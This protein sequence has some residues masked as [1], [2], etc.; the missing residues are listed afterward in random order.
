MTITPTVVGI[1]CAL[2]AVHFV[3]REAIFERARIRKGQICFPPVFGLRAT[4]W[5]GTPMFLFA[6]YKVSNEA[7]SSFDWV[8]PL[9]FVGLALLAFFSNPGTIT[10]NAEEISIKRFLGLRVKRLDWQS[11]SSAVHSTA[12]KE[13]VLYA[14]DGTSIT[15]TR[16]HVDPSRFEAELQKR[17]GPQFIQQ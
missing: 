9:I 6:A 12:Q 11:V 2:I 17:L 4:F 13:I 14:K 1:V 15:H 10:L 16:F 3:M 7:G 8:Y 5:L